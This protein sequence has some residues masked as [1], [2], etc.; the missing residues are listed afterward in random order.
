MKSF[1]KFSAFMVL[2]VMVS[3]SSAFISPKMQFPPGFHPIEIDNGIL[4]DCYTSIQN[5]TLMGRTATVNN[6]KIICTY[7]SVPYAAPP[8]GDLRFRV[9]LSTL[10][11]ILF[12]KMSYLI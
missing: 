1:Q 8:V 6:D 4:D 10:I 9:P 5:G 12:I 3:L 11:K 7:K 2:A